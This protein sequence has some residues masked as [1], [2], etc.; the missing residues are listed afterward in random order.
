MTTDI[1][2]PCELLCTH[3]IPIHV[4]N[5]ILIFMDRFDFIY[6]R[7]FFSDFTSISLFFNT[8]QYSYTI[9]YQVSVT[10]SYFQ[11]TWIQSPGII[12][13]IGIHNVLIICKKSVGGFVFWSTSSEFFS[14]KALKWSLKTMAEQAK[15]ILKQLSCSLNWS[16]LQYNWNVPKSTRS[17]QYIA[18][19]E[20]KNTYLK[21]Q[22]EVWLM[23][24]RS[25]KFNSYSLKPAISFTPHQNISSFLWAKTNYSWVVK[26]VEISKK[27]LG[28]SFFERARFMLWQTFRHAFYL[29][30]VWIYASIFSYSQI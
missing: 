24:K 5:Q 9:F 6:R 14:V 26:R 21:L 12:T 13:L 17:M 10:H 25:K 29:V 28:I 27:K 3:C 19:G 15:C 30:C 18:F 1:S 11:C 2:E 22:F 16:Q 4:E 23:K 7:N 20:L 8:V